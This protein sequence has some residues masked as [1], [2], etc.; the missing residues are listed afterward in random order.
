MTG[1]AEANNVEVVQLLLDH[2]RSLQ[3]VTTL[4]VVLVAAAEVRRKEFMRLALSINLR[5]RS[6]PSVALRWAAECGHS[7]WIK[8]LLDNGVDVNTNYGLL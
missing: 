6:Q 5:G 7:E 4:C 1:A 8:P 3:A 2:V